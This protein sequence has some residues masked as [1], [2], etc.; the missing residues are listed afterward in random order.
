MHPWNPLS[1]QSFHFPCSY[2]LSN[3]SWM[4]NYKL[5]MYWKKFLGIMSLWRWKNDVMKTGGIDKPA[6]IVKNLHGKNI[7]LFKKIICQ[8]ISWKYIKISD[9]IFG[10]VFLYLSFYVKLSKS[11]LPKWTQNAKLVWKSD[12]ISLTVFWRLALWY[13]IY[14][15]IFPESKAN[16]KIM[17]NRALFILHKNA[18]PSLFHNAIKNY[19]IHTQKKIISWLRKCRTSWSLFFLCK[20]WKFWWN[21]GIPP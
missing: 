16:R 11:H 1:I 6:F 21:F 20:N 15:N 8:H 10:H 18:K 7:K 19:L 13:E 14:F 12:N 4:F 9:K 3:R 2:I 17:Y 5:K